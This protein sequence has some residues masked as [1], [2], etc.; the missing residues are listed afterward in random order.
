MKRILLALAALTLSAGAANAQIGPYCIT[1]DNFC[2]SITIDAGESGGSWDIFCDGGA[3]A[4]N[5]DNVIPLAAGARGVIC[6]TPGNFACG[7]FDDFSFVFKGGVSGLF[8]LFGL[9]T[10]ITYQA[11]QPYTVIPGACTFAA[12]G[13]LPRLMD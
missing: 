9:T 4:V 12:R 13:N 2:D 11:D 7:G 1:F 10:G 5:I 6:G 3:G 8:N